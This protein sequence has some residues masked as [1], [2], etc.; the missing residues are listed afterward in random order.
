MAFTKNPKLLIII[1]TAAAL[2]LGVSTMAAI[3]VNQNVSSTGTITTS[4]NIGVYSD[5]GCT[6]NVTSI[7]WGSIAAGG[8]STHTVYVKNTGTGTMTLGLST[9]SWSP[10]G[11]GTYITVSWNK[12]GTTLSAGSSV[13]ATIT[14][15]VSSSITGITTFGNSITISGTG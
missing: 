5:S 2:S 13:A 11:A 9:S 3:S 12:E 10:A 7:A 8:S 1:L 14:L 4:P 6:T 15:S